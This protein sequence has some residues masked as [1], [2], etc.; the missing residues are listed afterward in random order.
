MSKNYSNTKSTSLIFPFLLQLHTNYKS[1][2]AFVLYRYRYNI[3]L[4]QFKIQSSV[5][6]FIS[7]FMSFFM[8]IRHYRRA[9]NS[10]QQPYHLKNLFWINFLNN[11]KPSNLNK[12][13]YTRHSS[14]NTKIYCW[15]RQKKKKI[16]K[17]RNKL[18]FGTTNFQ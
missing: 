12:L 10:I 14:I 7:F 5:L 6:L 17:K 1:T 8:L 2:H 3:Y 16:N 9:D 15:H 13:K 11:F 18:I 4:P